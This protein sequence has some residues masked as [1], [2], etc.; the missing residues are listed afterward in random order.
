M[1]G[2]RLASSRRGSRLRLVGMELRGMVWVGLVNSG[3]SRKE[4]QC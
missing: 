4:N 1:L 3:C 2:L